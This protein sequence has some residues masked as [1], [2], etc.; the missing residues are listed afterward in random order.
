MTY[1]ILV[2]GIL[3]TRFFPHNTALA[4]DLGFRRWQQKVA[5]SE[6]VGDKESTQL[7]ITLGVP[8]VALVVLLLILHHL[9]LRLIAYAVSL[10]GLLY[11]FGA[12]DLKNR[13]A[14]YVEA[15]NRNDVQAAF[16]DA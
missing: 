5:S 16:H 6:Q 2:L 13:I 15:L 10:I 7:Y 1:L 11:A 8:I 12:N 3:L 9:E 4:R 14:D